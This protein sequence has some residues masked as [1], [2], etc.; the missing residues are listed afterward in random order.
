MDAR[1]Y[2]ARVQRVSQR[3]TLPPLPPSLALESSYL[4]GF[5]SWNSRVGEYEDRED[6][7]KENVQT[8]CGREGV[9]DRE[10][11]GVVW[12]FGNVPS[13]EQSQGED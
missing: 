8:A 1:K 3:L 9:E 2:H 11:K 13:R 4:C 5:E 10:M 7:R 6:R 12:G